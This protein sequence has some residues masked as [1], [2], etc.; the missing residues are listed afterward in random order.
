MYVET[1]KM[2]EICRLKGIFLSLLL[3]EFSHNSRKMA[4]VRCL[5]MVV[6]VSALAGHSSGSVGLD[7]SVDSDF[8][9]SVVVDGI[10]WLRSSAVSHT[11]FHLWIN[12]PT[13]P[14]QWWAYVSVNPCCCECMHEKRALR[15][16][17]LTGC[18]E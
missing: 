13:V 7:V 6:V 2:R 18:S 16:K 12:I 4:G 17:M 9:Y 10:T 1:E 14:V 11:S 3:F 5:S 15:D 8:S